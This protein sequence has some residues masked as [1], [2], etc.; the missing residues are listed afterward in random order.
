MAQACHSCKHSTDVIH[1]VTES[2]NFC[3]TCDYLRHCNNLHE[4]HVRYQICDNCKRN[5]ALLLCCDDEMALCQSCYS[6][7]FKCTTLRHHIQILSCFPPP[8]HNTT[9]QHHEHA[10]MPHV[11]QHSNHEHE[12]VAGLGHQH[13]R[14]AG[15]FEMSCNGNTNCER[16]M[17]AM[18]CESCLAS[19]AVV[20]CRGHDKLMCH[21]CDRVFHLHEAVPPHLRCM[22]CGNCKRPSR[23]F[24]IG[25]AGHQ[26][27][28]PPTVHPPAAEEVSASPSTGLNQQ[29]DVLIRDDF[30]R[31]NEYPQDIYDFSWFGG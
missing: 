20:Y 8:H 4:E 30:F 31:D 11:V 29:D 25:A 6:R 23:Y 10:H 21:N 7:Y 24:L 22:L 9:N 3:L 17:F 5:P 16:W 19:D 26:F 1:C 15:M 12:H 13:Q 28:F 2:L 27:T 18:R 14:R